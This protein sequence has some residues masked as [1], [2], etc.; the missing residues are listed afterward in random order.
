VDRDAVDAI[1]QHGVDDR[2]CTEWVTRPQTE[3]GLQEQEGR[4]GRPGLSE[5]G[6]IL[7]R[8][9]CVSAITGEATEELR[10]PM[11]WQ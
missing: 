8:P 5:Q 1:R 10:Q 6:Q 7:R 9:R 11:V 4:C 3:G 2:R